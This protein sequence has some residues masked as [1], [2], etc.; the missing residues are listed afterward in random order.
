M[1]NTIDIK[2][3]ADMPITDEFA[4]LLFGDELRFEEITSEQN[5]DEEFVI[6]NG[7]NK[8]LIVFGKEGSICFIHHWFGEEEYADIENAFQ[9]VRYIDNYLNSV[10]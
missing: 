10:K 7:I 8:E 5:D 3:L 9:I 6:R 2:R 4:R 1:D